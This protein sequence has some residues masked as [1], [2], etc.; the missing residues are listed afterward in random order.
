M[1]LE[2]AL[3]ILDDT[4]FGCVY[5]EVSEALDVV[6]KV[7][8]DHKQQLEFWKRE[9]AGAYNAGFSDGAGLTDD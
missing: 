9:A 4:D 6:Y 5:P 7:A 2:E 8:H 1:T 3:K